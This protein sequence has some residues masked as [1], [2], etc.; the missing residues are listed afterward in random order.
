[1][2]SGTTISTIENAFI[3]SSAEECTKYYHEKKKIPKEFI[4]MAAWS[5]GQGR[6]KRRLSRF[7]PLH[8][9]VPDWDP[10]SQ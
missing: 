6:P 8:P 7:I 1:M 4:S 10:L 9:G 2:E 5:A 3:F